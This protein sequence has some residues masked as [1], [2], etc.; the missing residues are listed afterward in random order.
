[1]DEFLFLIWSNKQR[2]WWRPGACGVT[3][4]V[5]EAGRFPSDVA[6]QYVAQSAYAG[7]VDAASVMVVAPEAWGDAAPVMAKR[8]APTQG[9]PII[10]DVATR[11][12]VAIRCADCGKV[13]DWVTDVNKRRPIA[14]E[15]LSL[16]TR[17]HAITCTEQS[18]VP[19]VRSLHV[20]A[21]D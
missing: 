20:V 13:L 21:T 17:A 2:A 11:D 7:R 8:A 9:V 19:P 12:M 1:M 3:E 15:T 5:D 10:L 4:N 16:K 18:S 6:V 14:V